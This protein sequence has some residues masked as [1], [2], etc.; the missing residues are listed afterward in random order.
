MH[1]QELVRECPSV[2]VST[3]M[4]VLHPRG[5]HHPP[6]RATAPCRRAAG[7]SVTVHLW[8]EV[9][10]GRSLAECQCVSACVGAEGCS[11]HQNTCLPAALVAGGRA[12]RDPAP[13]C[14]SPLPL[15]GWLPSSPSLDS[16]PWTRLPPSPDLVTASHCD[17]SVQ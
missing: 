12:R 11:R 5:C 9:G 14:P 8:R 13:S 2:C 17:P 1:A 7:S 4:W 15:E 3:S 10:G 16:G 6:Q